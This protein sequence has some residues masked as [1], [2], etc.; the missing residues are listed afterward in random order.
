MLLQIPKHYPENAVLHG[1]EFSGHKGDVPDGIANVLK[2]FYGAEE[3][4]EK[5]VGK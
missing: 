5:K 3:V 2:G 4:T 1:V